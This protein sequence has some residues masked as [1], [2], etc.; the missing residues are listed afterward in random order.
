[1]QEYAKK[2]PNNER[3]INHDLDK[4]MSIIAEGENTVS[5]LSIGG[6]L[7]LGRYN[8]NSKNSGAILVKL[9]RIIALLSKAKSLP[10]NVRIKLDMTPAERKI[11]SLFFKGE[12]A[13]YL[14]WH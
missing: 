12:M 4:I 3:L 11:E 6:L 9:D 10:K 14:R 13:T 1:M 7:G 8:E 2:T 5:L